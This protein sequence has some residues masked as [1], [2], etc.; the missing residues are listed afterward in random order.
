MRTYLCYITLDR[1]PELKINLD[2]T[3]GFFDE[4]IVVDGG[5]T[6]GTLAYIR[7][8][9]PDIHLIEAPWRDDFAWSR[10][11]YLNKI[12]ELREP[13]EVS[14][15][16]RTD[17]DE[18]YAEQTLYN[19][20]SI[21]EQ[22]LQE[23]YNQVCL[24]CFDVI[25][26]KQKYTDYHKPLLHIFEPGMK[27]SDKIH[28]R[29]VSPYNVLQKNNNFLYTHI[30]NT[31]DV[32][33]RAARNFYLGEGFHKSPENRAIHAELLEILGDLPDHRAFVEILKSGKVSPELERFLIGYKDYGQ[34][35]NDACYT[36]IRE[37]FLLWEKNCGK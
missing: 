24:H 33:G 31:E 6:D 28:E 37:L 14:I 12:E 10:N 19:I 27:Y 30:R 15:Y 11:Q 22:A 17:T 5:S 20:K 8:H 29:L 21:I 16:C 2:A 35:S 13:G 7:K 18:F 32:W 34:P 26:G 23:G 36:E 25:N 1:F 4:T 3:Q 9:R